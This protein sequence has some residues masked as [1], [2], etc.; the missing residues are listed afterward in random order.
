MLEFQNYKQK[1]I[2]N[3]RNNHIYKNILH[4][5]S[6]YLQYSKRWNKSNTN[7][8]DMKDSK[9]S[10]QKKIEYMFQNFSIFIMQTKVTPFDFIFHSYIY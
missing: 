10:K 9:I 3:N 2:E 5:L 7:F 8:K 6:P 4:K 1:T